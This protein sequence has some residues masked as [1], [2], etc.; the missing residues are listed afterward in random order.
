MW[1]S[2][3][4]AHKTNE[5]FD[6][7]FTEAKKKPCISTFHEEVDSLE[8]S[9]VHANGINYDAQS[10]HGTFIIVLSLVDYKCFMKQNGSDCVN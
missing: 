8:W 7:T 10:F 1:G 5:K 3:V 4:C 6:Y 9:K 2:R